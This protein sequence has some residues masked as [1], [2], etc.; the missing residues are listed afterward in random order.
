M[1]VAA[2]AVLLN[3]GHV[4]RNVSTFGSGSEHSFG[5]RPLAEA[6]SLRRS[7]YRTPSVAAVH[8]DT[9]LDSVTRDLEAAVDALSS[10]RC[11]WTRRI[12]GSRWGRT[13]R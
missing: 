1:L 12:R 10:V 6:Y 9:P 13:S 3:V 8:F 2:V 11:G 4:G 7:S 5:L